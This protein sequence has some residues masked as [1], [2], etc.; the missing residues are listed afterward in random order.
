MSVYVR[1]LTIDTHVDFTE[2]LELYQLGGQTTNITG[3]SLYSHMR[4][5]PDSTKK[6]D[7]AVGITSAFDGEITLSL[8]STITSELK[9]GRYVYDLLVQR[10]NGDRAI[11]LE[12][13][14]N[15]RAGMSHSCP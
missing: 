3:Y 11:V 8:G 2:N 7:F 6:T 10:T 5:H 9:P 12:G 15:V 13:T 4:K 14:V 1:N